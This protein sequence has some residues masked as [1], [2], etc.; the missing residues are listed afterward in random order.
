MVCLNIIL[1]KTLYYPEEFPIVFI[2]SQDLNVCDRNG[3]NVG[4]A[5]QV[6]SLSPS[7]EEMLKLLV[8]FTTIT[9]RFMKPELQYVITQTFV[10]CFIY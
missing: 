2:S 7:E 9:K 3:R 4:S 5:L 8:V 1:T 10:F 6:S